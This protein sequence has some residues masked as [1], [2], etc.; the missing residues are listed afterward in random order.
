MA[1]GE[2]YS[3]PPEAW[4]PVTERL[5]LTD[6]QTRELAEVFNLYN[7]MMGQANAELRSLLERLSSAIGSDV[8][9]DV[10]NMSRFFS[11]PS[12]DD[13]QDLTSAW[14]VSLF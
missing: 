5:L 7:S 6:A 2:L 9:Y 10:A 1:T 12:F 3:A 11:D 13:Q 8:T 4:G 14:L